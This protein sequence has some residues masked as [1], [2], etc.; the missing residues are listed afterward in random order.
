MSKSI[1]AIV[2]LVGFVIISI[3]LTN[4]KLDHPFLTGFFTG[5]I[6]TAIVISSTKKEDGKKESKG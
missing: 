6:W 2:W 1:A 5:L 4:A 3:F